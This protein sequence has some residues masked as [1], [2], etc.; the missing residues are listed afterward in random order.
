MAWELRQTQDGG[1]YWEVFQSAYG[2]SCGAEDTL[3][4]AVAKLAVAEGELL[5]APMP[6]T[7]ATWFLDHAEDHLRAERFGLI[8]EIDRHVFPLDEEAF[9]EHLRSL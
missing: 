1:W 7:M 2:L 5:E 9:K 4:M 3:A 8:D 6:A